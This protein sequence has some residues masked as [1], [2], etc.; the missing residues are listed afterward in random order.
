MEFYQTVE[1]ARTALDRELKIQLV[2]VGST[3]TELCRAQYPEMLAKLYRAGASVPPRISFDWVDSDD[4][5]TLRALIRRSE[6]TYVVAATEDASALRAVPTATQAERTSFTV[7]AWLGSPNKAPHMKTPHIA[8]SRRVLTPFWDICSSHYVISL[9]GIDWTDIS[10]AFRFF[11]DFSCTEFKGSAA[12]EQLI[13]DQDP[14]EHLRKLSHHET[15][16]SVFLVTYLRESVDFSLAADASSQILA[17]LPD[18]ASVILNMWTV[19]P[20]AL[21][22]DVLIRIYYGERRGIGT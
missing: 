19:T 7:T 1:D 17:L 15:P 4:V 9:I 10:D 2:S 6:F 5:I 18:D 22:D 12:S 13:F 14:N 21:R 11:A 16:L 20:S 8:V 3:A